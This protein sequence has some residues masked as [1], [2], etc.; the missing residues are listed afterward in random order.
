MYIQTFFLAGTFSKSKT[1]L[2]ASTIARWSL[3]QT[4][5]L[6]VDDGIAQ[7]W[8]NPNTNWDRFHNGGRGDATAT[9]RVVALTP[10]VSPISVPARSALPFDGKR[11]SL[12]HL[13][14]LAAKLAKFPL[15]TIDPVNARRNYAEFTRAETRR[16]IPPMRA[17]ITYSY[18][19]LCSV[20]TGNYSAL[21]S[22]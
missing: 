15:R 14:L 16:E 20:L 9:P 19:R 2:L 7:T 5:S 3:R 8:R 1:I 12:E 18:T 13:Q 22:R 6:T 17:A 21:R 11:D 10:D 4:L